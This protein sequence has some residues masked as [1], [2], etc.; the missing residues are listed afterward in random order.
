M[1]IAE[2]QSG[3]EKKI[4]DLFQLSF[5]QT[6]APE[7]WKWRFVDNP[8]GSKMIRLMW[9]EDKLVGHYAVSP[10]S[11]N[12]N[13]EDTFTSHSLTTM[14]HPE[15]AGKGIFKKLS[16]ELYAHLE[17]ELGC[18][19]IWGYPNKNSHYTFIKNLG[20]H[21]ISTI[22][23]LAK[24]S[25]NL[26]ISD[27]SVSIQEIEAFSEKH[28]KTIAS[29]LDSY[30]IHVS[31]SI[32]Y[33]N[34]RFVA[35]PS[36]DYKIFEVSTDDGLGI[37][38]S[39]LYPLG[40]NSYDLNIVES[41]IPEYS[42]FD[43]IVKKIISHYQDNLIGRISLWKNLHDPSHISL[44]RIGYTAQMPITYLGARMTK[45]VKDVMS[46]YRNWYVSMG[47]SDVY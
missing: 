39:K 30:I 47:D 6:M 20:W 9:D 10:V 40:D 38:V 13:G 26:K 33:L 19:A 27:T 31:R 1:R 4:I 37:L 34:W 25:G 28:S 3:D 17:S 21:D 11:V 16:L 32:K 43:D 35:K 23:K 15:Y 24:D 18:K 45:D 7:Q 29:Y 41:F 36:T 22:H 42:Y 46:D 12:I 2:Y 14:T 8:A 5:G 44:E